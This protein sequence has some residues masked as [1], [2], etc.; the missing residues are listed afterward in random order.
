MVFHP[1]WRELSR[2]GA[3]RG[4]DLLVVGGGI[5]GCGV[6]LDAALRGLRVALI[7]RE[8]LAS[9][10]SSRSSKLL[11]GG[12]RYL[13]QMQIRVTRDSCRE[14]DLQ[15][16]LNPHLVDP[17]RF[18]YPAYRGDRTPGWLVEMGLRVYDRLTR[19]PEKHASFGA[20]ELQELVP[21]VPT[22]DLERALA[23]W[24]ARVDDARLT[25]AVAARGFEAGGWV[26]TRAEAD[27]PLRTGDGRLRGLR[28]RDLEEGDVV[29]VEA[30]VVVNAAGVGVDRVRERLGLDDA[31]VRPSRGSHLVLDGRRLALSSA[32]TIPSPDDH[33]PVFFLPH[34]EG[35]LVGTTDLF[36]AGELDD[37]RPT[38][39]EVDYLLRAARTAF[40]GAGLREA[41]VR[42]T[43]AGL[44]PVLATDIDDPSKA[45]REEDVWWEDGLLSVAGGKLTTWRATAETVVDRALRHLPDEIVRHA[46]PCATA[47]TPLADLAPRD[48]PERLRSRGVPAET[49]DGLARRLG[50][51]SWGAVD[52][53]A[54][55]QLRPVR[56]GLDLSAAEIREHCRSGAVLHLDDL[57]LRRCRLGMWRPAETA[58]LAPALEAV[59]RPALGWSG[60]RWEDEMER[61]GAR[62]RGWSPTGIVESDPGGD[63]SS[64]GEGGATER[65]E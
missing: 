65:R 16:V 6:L 49:A 17:L 26:W 14:R 27:E 45:S 30:G 63:S 21:G 2:D 1:G 54:D 59:V 23:Y 25:W 34:P 3:R 20:D 37:P 50:A 22:E 32:V 55:G 64:D 12:L 42:G 44:R 41:D 38:R 58:A 60:R 4:V 48:L 19:R 8:D 52:R 39:H 56:D 33:R 28:V 53:A 13:K 29:D 61:L 24:D 51:R 9:G 18:L 47:G 57:L 62:L 11:H 36:H 31:R 7:E 5:T 10:T 40:P 43:F 46:G 15:L 35:T